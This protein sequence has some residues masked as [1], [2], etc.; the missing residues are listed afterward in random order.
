MHTQKEEE[1]GRKA[2]GER[3]RRGR[4][5]LSLSLSLSPQTTHLLAKDGDRDTPIE[6]IIETQNQTETW[7]QRYTGGDADSK[8]R[9]RDR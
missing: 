3:G 4:I 8:N 9:I 1:R 7:R 6:P 2:E 5:D